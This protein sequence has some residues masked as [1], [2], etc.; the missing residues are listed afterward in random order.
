[1]ACSAKPSPRAPRR[2]G[3][4]CSRELHIPAAPLRTTDELFDNAHLDA[5]GFFESV[6]TPQGK[7]RFPGVPTWFSDTPGRVAGPCPALGEHTGEVLAE[8]GLGE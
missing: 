2:N 7:M 6:E 3:S 1:M 5:V 4:T 8:L